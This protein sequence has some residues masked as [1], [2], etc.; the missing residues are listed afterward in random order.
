MSKAGWITSS[1]RIL[2]RC[3]IIFSCKI[4]FLFFSLTYVGI[5]G[6]FF[7][8]EVGERKV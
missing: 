6:T 3:Q 8:V 2:F 7:C 1:M 5:L 4:V